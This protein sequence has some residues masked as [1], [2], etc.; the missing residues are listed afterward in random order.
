VSGPIVVLSGGVGGAQFVRG[1]IEV[2][3]RKD[4]VVIGNTGD[5]VEVWGL[6]VSPDLDTV[7]YTLAG[8]IHPEQKWG[9]DEETFHCLAEVA[10]YGLPDWFRLGDKDLATHLF[11]T[12][13]L[14]AGRTLS[15]VTAELVSAWGLGVRLVPMSDHPVRT[16]VVTDSGEL[17]FQDY[18]VRRQAQDPV[19]GVR[20][21]GAEQS[22]A[23]P[24][25]LEAL[26]EARAIIVAPSNPILSIQPIL[27]VPEIRDALRGA[28][29]K[30]VA[31]SPL[32]R[33]QA[34]KGPTVACLEGLGFEASNHGIATVYAA[35]IDG[36]L[37]DAGD[38][39]DAPKLRSTDLRIGVAQT[40]MRDLASA[41]RLAEAAL[42]LAG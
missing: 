25:I 24:G 37:I 28:R 40:L 12:S 6:H 32:I 23:A 30:C 20:F 27:S 35:L 31:V 26:A 39:G 21:A 36:L 5:D 4:V 10:R 15:E 11:R 8:A 38:E 29:G 7:L 34:V 16:H 17:P 19:R 14:R 42:R 18:F 9:R 33:A 3:P 13:G 41:A 2:V 1:L 22:R